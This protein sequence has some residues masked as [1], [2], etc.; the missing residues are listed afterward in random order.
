MHLNH[1]LHRWHGWAQK[2]Y[3]GRQAGNTLSKLRDL[4]RVAVRA[5]PG[6]LMA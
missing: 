1:G 5:F 6:K 4:R 2:G 3:E